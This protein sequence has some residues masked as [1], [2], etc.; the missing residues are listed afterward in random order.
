MRAA[1]GGDL[2]GSS[3]ER[4]IWSEGQYPDV[5][6]VGYAVALPRGNRSGESAAT[7]ELL[8]PSCHVTDDSILTVAVMD[9]LL[10]G[11]D[12]RLLLRAYFR[13]AGRP[14]LFGKVFRRRAAADTDQPRGSSGNGAAMRVSP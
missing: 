9:W 4:S 8:H 1:I 3:F 7:F 6:C 5:R 2:V 12:P 13:R 11:G 10:H 14:E